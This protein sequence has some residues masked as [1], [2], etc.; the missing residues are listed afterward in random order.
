MSVSFD[1]LMKRAKSVAV[2]ATKVA[3]D[4]VVDVVDTSKLKLAEAKLNGDIREVT[5]RLGSIVYEAAKTGRDAVKLQEMLIKELD[6]LYKSLE[7]LRKKSGGNVAL[8]CNDCG[9]KNAVN[10]IYCC[11]CGASLSKET[12]EYAVES[13][14]PSGEVEKTVEDMMDEI[15]EKVE[16]A[17]ETAADAAERTLDA[18]EKKLEDEQ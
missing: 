15:N 8:V 5:E 4:V 16:S 6:E 3:G 14:I 11:K 10:A 12:P 1:D 17:V 9:E 7:E 13:D 2:A 18:A